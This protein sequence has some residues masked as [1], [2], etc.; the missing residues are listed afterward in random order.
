MN[1]RLDVAMLGRPSIYWQGKRVAFPF[2]K[3]EALLYYLL[4]QGQATREELAGLLWSDM[5]DV[6]AKKNLRNTLYLL[7]KTITDE[8]IV[9]TGR[10]IIEINWGLVDTNDVHKFN[11]KGEHSLDA[12][13][14]SFLEGFSCREAV[15]FE[16]WVTEQREKYREN[17]TTQL[18]KHIVDLMNSKK[19]GDAKH[20]LQR[21]IKIDEYNESAYRALMR[22]YEREG[23]YHKLIE[24]YSTLKKKLASDLGIAPNEKTKEIYE[25][26]QSRNVV[27]PVIH[28]DIGDNFFFGREKELSGLFQSLDH[29]RSGK[30]SKQFVM[31]HGE[32]GVGKSAL[33]AK[34]IQTALH[35][36]ELVL[37]I[38]CYEPEV[39]YPY[40][41]W[42]TVFCQVMKVLS[43][44][45]VTIPIVWC[46]IIAYIFPSAVH[47]DGWQELNTYFD[48]DFIQPGAIE[49]V[50]CGI[51]GKLSRVR[52][53]ILLIEDVHWMD[54]Q[55]LSALKSFF[56]L[57]ESRIMC[58]STCRS[59]YVERLEQVF[60]NLDEKVVTTWLEVESFK[61]EDVIRFS[62]LV[63]PPD[64]IKS[65]VPQKL[66][67]Y[68]DGNA[69]FL[70]E[71]IKLIQL[72]HDVE[73]LSPKLQSVLNAR[74]I[75]LS[76]NSQKLLEVVSTFIREATYDT[77]VNVCG[78]NELELVEAV[79][80]ILQKRLLVEINLQ[81][82]SGLSYNF[83]HVLI[84]DYIY[85]KMSS[86]R[87]KM[88][89]QRIAVY[90]EQKMSAERK[91]RDLYSE[92]LHH[93][94]K[95]GQKMKVL[96]YTIKLAER[97]SSPHYEMFPEAYDD[98]RTGNGC[99][100]ADRL[101]IT[102]YLQEISGL[103]DSLPQEMASEET[104]CRHKA[105]YLE[106]LGRYHIW[107]GDHRK[108]LKVIHELLHLASVKEYPD[109]LIK[110]YQ[111]V[112][113][114]GI[115]TG[116]HK[117]VEAFAVKL[118]KTASELNLKDKMAT[119]LR[120]R[121]YANAMQR[122]YALAEQDYR[123]SIS[124]FR[125]LS[126]NQG[127]YAASIGAAYSY[128]GDIRRGESK[129]AD[130]LRYY[131]KA[132]ALY[133]DQYVGEALSIIFISAGTMAF[134]LEDYEKASKYF[135][136]ARRCGEQF[137]GQMGFW[138]RRSHCILDC[139]SALI[140]VRQGNLAEGLK[141]LKRAE[142]F[143]EQHSDGY[144]AGFAWRAKAEIAA[145]M[146]GDGRIRKVFA[147]YLSLPS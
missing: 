25:R 67:D 122:D 4:V 88:I 31:L 29:L 108:G 73:S 90:L 36:E 133:S 138:C 28:G 13:K 14:G 87:Q 96:E 124:L 129:F 64:K 1:N 5:D 20:S 99:M 63:L 56:R 30:N 137:G 7:K 82:G 126:N 144:A 75:H 147:E 41:A 50:L 33:L 117:L 123:Q 120:L 22:I 18:T 114:C 107:G 21:L 61:R 40:K 6:A 76:S 105:A 80:E 125:R 93:Y 66:Y 54:V 26:V 81:A 17:Y 92:V 100:I 127:K 49:E 48:G 109:Y 58:I 70:T 139:I 111:Q 106:M 77:L 134:E 103:L 140:A 55:G 74:I 131:E 128:I 135:A 143:F 2:C 84:R 91:A 8:L 44:V 9:T 136:E 53:I 42:S 95:A 132:V 113:Y 12:Y 38:Q 121:G 23:S 65:E 3:M 118:L 72:G 15:L 83:T 116:K 71:C 112:A 104:L 78:L 101:Q 69:L 51:L 57:P 59:E 141:C 27:S 102:N 62:T 98:S 16:D 130:A 34:F 97:F 86:S 119:A 89:H 39:N 52:K 60:G 47:S 85:S 142:R 32:Q 24:T 79:D 115:Q 94:T 10:L 37:Q 45:G 110:G 35:K 19:Y 146:D 46:Q 68:T 145:R 43:E 11:E